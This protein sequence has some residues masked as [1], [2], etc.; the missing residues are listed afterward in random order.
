MLQ[1]YLW[2]EF[3]NVVLKIKY[4]LCI[5]LGQSL[6]HYKILSAHLASA[7]TFMMYFRK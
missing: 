2:Y 6:T 1:L 3:R 4:K 7:I 5:G